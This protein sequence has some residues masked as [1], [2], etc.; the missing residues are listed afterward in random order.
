MIKRETFFEVPG[1]P[2]IVRNDIIDRQGRKFRVEFRVNGSDL[3]EDLVK[4]GDIDLDASADAAVDH[5]RH[6]GIERNMVFEWF[7][8]SGFTDVTV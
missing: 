8:N 6:E 7:P 2:H 1:S 5:L 4:H 3:T